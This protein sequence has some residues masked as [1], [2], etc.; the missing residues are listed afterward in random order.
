MTYNHIYQRITINNLARTKTQRAQTTQ[1]SYETSWWQRSL[2]KWER[3][4]QRLLF[5]NPEDDSF[6]ALLHTCFILIMFPIL[7]IIDMKYK[8]NI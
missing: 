2:R 6:C 4:D 8:I 5:I 7:H 1:V 3:E